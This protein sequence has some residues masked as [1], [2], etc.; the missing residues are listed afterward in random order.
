MHKKRLM[1]NINFVASGVEYTEAIDG[2]IVQVSFDE[3]LDEDLDQDPFSQTTCYLLISQNYEFPGKPTVEWHDGKT[4][5][6]GA[7]VANYK[8]TKDSFELTT[9]NSTK[10]EIQHNCNEKTFLQIQR[11]LYREFGDSK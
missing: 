11:F 3:V 8:F 7:E 1:T 2:E 9:T 6:G 4:D 5:D 10:F